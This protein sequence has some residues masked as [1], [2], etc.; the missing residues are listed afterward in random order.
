MTTKI[1]GPCIFVQNLV[2]SLSMKAG[3]M[4]SISL[5]YVLHGANYLSITI[6]LDLSKASVTI[7]KQ[8]TNILGG[9]EGVLSL[10]YHYSIHA[11]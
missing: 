4:N 2:Y 1:S 11:S 3:R 7:F 5:K 6:P 10:C 9:E 8:G